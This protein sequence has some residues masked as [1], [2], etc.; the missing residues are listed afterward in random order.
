MLHNYGCLPQTWEDPSV[1]QTPEQLAG[2]N[3]PVDVVEI[4]ERIL[5]VG[6]IVEVKVQS[7]LWKFGEREG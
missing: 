5:A 1:K 3:D 7:V 6:E 4:G 2:D